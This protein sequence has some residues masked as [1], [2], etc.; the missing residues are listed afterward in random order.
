MA[1]PTSPT[2]TTNH[3]D[4]NAPANQ[5]NTYSQLLPQLQQPLH[6]LLTN[7]LLQAISGQPNLL[8]HPP[9]TITSS[10]T[11]Q[12]NC[13]PIPM[14]IYDQF[15]GASGHPS[16]PILPSPANVRVYAYAMFSKCDGSSSFSPKD[17]YHANILTK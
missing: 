15:S 9:A 6:H 3:N 17:F 11:R 8:Q 13:D 4:I 10:Q 7:S 5:S 14:E 2:S 1:S 16:P 12:L